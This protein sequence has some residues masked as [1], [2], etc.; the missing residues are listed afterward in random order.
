MSSVCYCGCS[1]SP[2]K[3]SPALLKVQPLSEKHARFDSRQQK[4]PNRKI[5]CQVTSD[6]CTTGPVPMIC[7]TSEP[8]VYA[9]LKIRFNACRT[10]MSPKAEKMVTD[11]CSH[12]D[13]HTAG[14]Q[15]S[16]Y[17]ASWQWKH[18]KR[19]KVDSWW[20]DDIEIPTVHSV[21]Q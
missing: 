6:S 18:N 1:L 19:I 3:V 9:S 12:L 21:T 10:E 13:K 8:H 15:S 7:I 16:T 4:N 20:T 11:E 14:N 17:L 5:T 2:G